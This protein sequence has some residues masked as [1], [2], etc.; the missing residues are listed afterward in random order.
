[1]PNMH[2][3]AGEQHAAGHPV[4]WSEME[5]LVL[6]R[7]WLRHE[8]VSHAVEGT[9]RSADPVSKQTVRC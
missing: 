6:K 9:H 7:V 3:D 4:T 5:S 8:G 1:M 2:G